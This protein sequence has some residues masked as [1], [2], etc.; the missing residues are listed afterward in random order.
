MK[1]TKEAFP[2]G[3]TC[4]SCGTRIRSGQN[5]YAVPLESETGREMREGFIVRRPFCTACA[6]P[7][8]VK[9]KKLQAKPEKKKGNPQ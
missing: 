8:G 4:G 1:V 7:V 5:Y 6:F 2:A 9:I 3:L